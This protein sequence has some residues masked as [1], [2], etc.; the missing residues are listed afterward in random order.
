MTT[1]ICKSG[2][3]GWEAKLQKVYIDFNEFE[4]WNATYHIA[5]RLGYKSA[6]SAWESNPTVRGSIDPSDLERGKG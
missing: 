2:I 4:I 1:V 5:K 6:R 3:R